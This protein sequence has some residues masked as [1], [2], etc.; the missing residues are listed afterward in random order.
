MMY[1]RYY[2][3]GSKPKFVLSDEQFEKLVQVF[4]FES[5]LEKDS[6][7]IDLIPETKEEAIQLMNEGCERV[8]TNTRWYLDNLDK[9]PTFKLK[10]MDFYE[11][12]S[13]KHPKP[14]S[15]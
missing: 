3:R 4:G 10:Y 2:P 12:I 1:R 8:L 7:S 5:A 11:F 15:I 6:A 9:V 13:K 14:K